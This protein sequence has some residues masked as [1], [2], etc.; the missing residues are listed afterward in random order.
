MDRNSRAGTLQPSTTAFNATRKFGY[1]V[2]EHMYHKIPTPPPPLQGSVIY[3]GIEQEISS[4]EESDSKQNL[5]HEAVGFETERHQVL[6]S[7]VAAMSGTT[8]PENPR[9]KAGQ[10]YLKLNLSGAVQKV[11]SSYRCSFR[12]RVY[13][14]LN[15]RKGN[16]RRRIV[17]RV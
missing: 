15:Y 8:V 7:P 16:G 9:G 17:G 12:S 11:H 10:L 1:I 4:S 14:V 3:H 13:D 2:G 6:Q 5:D